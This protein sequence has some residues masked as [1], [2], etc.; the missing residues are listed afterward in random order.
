MK[1]EE[2]KAMVVVGVV[3]S[4]LTSRLQLATIKR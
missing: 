4:M 1:A 3:E 2:L